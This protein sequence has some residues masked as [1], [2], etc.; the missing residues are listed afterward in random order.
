MSQ[1][2]NLSKSLPLWT[3]QWQYKLICKDYSEHQNHLQLIRL[4]PK[5]LVATCFECWIKNTKKC[6]LHGRH[7]KSLYFNTDCEEVVCDICYDNQG[8]LNLINDVVY[9]K[10][11]LTKYKD[12][13]DINVNYYKEDLKKHKEKIN[14]PM[15]RENDSPVSK[16]INPVDSNITT[17]EPYYGVSV[18]T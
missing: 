17:K 12:C 10:K 3:T 15:M 5:D 16:E 13:K 9:C 11:C 2:S 6:P 8:Y 14:A 18:K 1:T 7:A 4:I